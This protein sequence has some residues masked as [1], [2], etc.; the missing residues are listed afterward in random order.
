MCMAIHPCTHVHPKYTLNFFPAKAKYPDRLCTLLSLRITWKDSFLGKSC[1][2]ALNKNSWITPGPHTSFPF[3]LSILPH[4][5]FTFRQSCGCV[6]W[7]SRSCPLGAFLPQ[8]THEAV[9]GAH[10]ETTWERLQK[11]LV[12]KVWLESGTTQTWNDDCGTWYQ[13]K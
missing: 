7:A 6:Q 5:S 9:G 2:F 12:P 4:W 10:W 13:M 8:L 1:M 11:P 3:L